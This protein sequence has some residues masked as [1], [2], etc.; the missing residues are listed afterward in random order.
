MRLCSAA[1]YVAP[2]QR[3][4]VYGAR[5]QKSDQDE[6]RTL[7]ALLF[8][9]HGPHVCMQLGVLVAQHLGAKGGAARLVHR[10]VEEAVARCGY[11]DRLRTM[12]AGSGERRVGRAEASA[13]GGQG[14]GRCKGAH[15]QGVRWARAKRHGWLSRQRLTERRWRAGGCST[16]RRA[17]PCGRV[18]TRDKSARRRRRR[19]AYP[20]RVQVLLRPQVVVPLQLVDLCRGP[21]EGGGSRTRRRR[22]R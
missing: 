8:G 18:A 11:F 7:A 13:K 1:A 4:G 10:V 22:R 16:K 3:G 9:G 21:R 5:K 19:L 15:E 6:K 12:A 14:K 2:V 20:V 17:Q